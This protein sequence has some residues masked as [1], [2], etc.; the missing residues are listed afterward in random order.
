VHVDV[1]IP[2][3]NYPYDM[4]AKAITKSQTYVTCKWDVP[5]NRLL[6]VSNNGQSFNIAFVNQ[7]WQILGFSPTDNMIAGTAV[8]STQPLVARQNSE[9]YIRLNNVTT[10][11]GNL[12]YDNYSGKQ[13]SP[14]TILSI[15]PIQVAPYQTQWTDNSVYGQIVGV[16]V[17]NEKLNNLSIDIVDANG[18]YADWISD[19]RRH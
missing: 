18:N 15:I 6:F 1:V 14:S 17:A 2:T 3:G 4:L 11:D 12:N 5:S 19:W 8:I 10:G 16:F 7:A 13:L 9:L